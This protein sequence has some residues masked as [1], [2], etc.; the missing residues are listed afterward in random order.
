MSNKNE[1]KVLA[2]EKEILKKEEAILREVKAEE[3]KIEGAGKRVLFAAY[4][5]LLLVVLAIGGF[6]YWQYSSTRISIDKAQI[7]A[8]EIDLGPSA[9]GVLQEVFVRVG[10]TVPADTVV[11]RVDNQSIKTKVG[12]LVINVQKDIG[13]RFNP[14]EAIVS[15]IDPNE[16]RVVGRLE[17][18]KGLRDVRVGQT[19]SFTVD[20]FG[21]RTFYGTVDSISP[22]S[23]DSGIVFNISDKRET[24]EFDVDVRYDLDAYPELRN[25]M[26]AK[27]VIQK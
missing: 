21:S 10:D 27:I 4:G 20:A 13:K 14:G 16:L 7:T 9:P 23:R 19:A 25:G 6:S 5:A 17:E 1:N 22:T 3:K 18:D 24:Q 8:P 12:G 2:Q 26:S 15:L 11:A